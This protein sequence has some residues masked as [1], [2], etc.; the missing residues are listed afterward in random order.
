MESESIF[1]LI[2]FF[3]SL[4]RSAKPEE[5]KPAAEV[6]TAN[7]IAAPPSKELPPSPDK[8]AKV[9]VDRVVLP[10]LR[11]LVLGTLLSPFKPTISSVL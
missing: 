9:R 11:V 4:L 1:K 5:I 7:D 2:S 6:T 10:A 3:P 8:K